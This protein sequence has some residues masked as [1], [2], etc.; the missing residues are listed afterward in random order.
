[1][2]KRDLDDQMKD[3][4]RDETR[5]RAPDRLAERI[6]A[7]PETEPETITA[8]RRWRLRLGRWLGAGADVTRDASDRHSPSR[9]EERRNRFVITTAATLT[10]AI[11]VAAGAFY[12]NQPAVDEPQP[13]QQVFTAEFSQDAPP[14][15]GDFMFGIPV[16]V[17]QCNVRDVRIGERWEND[18]YVPHPDGLDRQAEPDSLDILRGEAWVADWEAQDPGSGLSD[19]RLTGLYSEVVDSNIGAGGQVAISTARLENDAGAWQGSFVSFTDARNPVQVNVVLEG[20]DSYE[21]LTALLSYTR[22]YFGRPQE[23]Q[24]LWGLISERPLPAVPSALVTGGLVPPLLSEVVLS[25]SDSGIEPAAPSIVWANEAEHTLI[26]T[27]TDT[28]EHGLAVVAEGS[29]EIVAGSEDDLLA[30]GET[31]EVTLFFVPEI[32]YTIYDPTDRDGT[33]IDVQ[34]VFRDQ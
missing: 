24:R 31:R 8:S 29:P 12:V 4:Y 1:M 34:V 27:N 14:A 16:W 21:G 19:P 17:D 32:A 5:D 28:V 22:E 26:V 11:A 15:I 30:P 23:C 33:A 13:A 2:P 3:W 25:L 20:Q 7:I 10:A 6:S 18:E 9:N